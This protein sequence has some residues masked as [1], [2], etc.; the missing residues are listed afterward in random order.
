MRLD[1]SIFDKIYSLSGQN[2]FLDGLFIFFADYLIYAVMLIFFWLVFFRLKDTKDRAYFFY[3][4]VLSVIFSWGIVTEI[5]RFFYYSPRPFVLEFES[6]IRH[7]DTSSFPSGHMMFIIPIVLSVFYID[8]KWGLILLSM[9][10]LTA[11]SR[12][13]VGVH[14]PIDI[15]GAFFLGPASFYS[16]KYLYDLKLRKRK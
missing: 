16:I 14:W 9:A 3:L 8:K 5:F 13:A 12:I 10:I 6:L 4:G 7:I 11:I 15:I 1:E 2:P